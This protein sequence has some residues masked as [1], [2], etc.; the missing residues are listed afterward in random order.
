M[1]PNEFLQKRNLLAV[2]LLSAVAPRLHHNRSMTQKKS[3]RKY[4]VSVF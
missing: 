4:F 2:D 3:E 1:R